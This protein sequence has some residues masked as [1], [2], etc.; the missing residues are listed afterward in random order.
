MDTMQAEDD[1]VLVR[2]GPCWPSCARRQ[3]VDAQGGP[4]GPPRNLR[5]NI[6]TPNLKNISYI[7]YLF[8]K[9]L[10]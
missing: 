2:R 1:R 8:D 10:L 4:S 5:K 9:F 7:Y 6:F 3:G